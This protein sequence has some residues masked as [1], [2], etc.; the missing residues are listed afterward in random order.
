VPSFL[1][2][3]VA[4]LLALAGGGSSPARHIT[5]AAQK[6]YA[7]KTVSCQKAGVMEILGGRSVVYDC[8]LTGIDAL[9]QAGLPDRDIGAAVFNRCFVDVDGVVADVTAVVDRLQSHGLTVG[10]RFAC[11]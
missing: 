4:T 9:H 2:S 5:A 3:V 6:E 8:K 7:A 10:G 11:H 1:L